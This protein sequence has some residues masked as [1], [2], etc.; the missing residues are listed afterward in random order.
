MRQRKLMSFKIAISMRV[1]QAQGYDEP[2]D[3]ISHD[4]LLWCQKN[5]FNPVL[6]P[7]VLTNPVAFLEKE[8]VN[9][10][11]LS[12]GEDIHPGAYDGEV[13]ADKR[14][15]QE[16]DRVEEDL[17]RWCVKSSLPVL[18]VCRGFQ[19]VNVIQGGRL[20]QDIVRDIEGGK[21]HVAK[22]HRLKSLDD[23]TSELIGN[24]EM[25]VNSFH[26]QGVT[27]G[28]LGEGLLPLL[29]SED[30][31]LEAYGMKGGKMLGIQ[32]HPERPGPETF[33]QEQLALTF[34]NEGSW[35]S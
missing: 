26:R 17:F 21:N 30:G 12:N 24:K 5:N 20:V 23:A 13:E 8:N 10:L 19:L 28:T 31:V 16:R 18:G 15:S 25:S 34:L 2:R 11:L 6:I 22:T 29:E 4:W 32:W 7:N 35:W 27:L 14:Y 9:A 1:V 33:C 3:A